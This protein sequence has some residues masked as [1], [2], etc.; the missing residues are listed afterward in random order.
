MVVI[1]KCKI[2]VDKGRD[3]LEAWK[4]MTRAFFKISFY[5][6]GGQEPP[7]SVNIRDRARRKNFR[8]N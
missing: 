5:L 3:W 7:Q 2:L 8:R 1:R 4:T 6:S